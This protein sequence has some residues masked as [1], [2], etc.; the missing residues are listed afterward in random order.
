MCKACCNS[1]DLD[2]SCHYKVHGHYYNWHYNDRAGS[3]KVYCND[4]GQHQNLVIRMSV[5]FIRASK[6]VS[7]LSPYKA[8]LCFVI[9]ATV[10]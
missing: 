5:F 1:D 3:Y 2:C 7:P 8:L 6:V 9:K 4:K 10:F